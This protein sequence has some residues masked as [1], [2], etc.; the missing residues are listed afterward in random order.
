M[1]IFISLIK[2]QRSMKDNFG[3]TGL[4]DCPVCKKKYLEE[5][6]NEIP[7]STNDIPLSS[8]NGSTVHLEE[9]KIIWFGCVHVMNEGIKVFH[10]QGNKVCRCCKFCTDTYFYKIKEIVNLKK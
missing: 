3:K 5:H 6:P 2:K 7:I 4:P 9:K 8:A 1:R 10:D